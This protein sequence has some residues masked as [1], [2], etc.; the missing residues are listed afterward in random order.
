MRA[1]L[2]A[3][4]L[5]VFPGVTKPYTS[6]AGPGEINLEKAIIVAAGPLSKAEN[7]AV[8]ML[9][10][11]IEKRTLIRPAVRTRWPED[12]TPVIA[13]GAAAAAKAWAGPY[14]G[15]LSQNPVQCAA[16]GYTI[17]TTAADVKPPAVLVSG[18]DTRGV[19]YG[20]G[21]LLR[22]LNMSRGRLTLTAGMSISTAPRFPIRGHQ[23]GYRPKTNSYD[24]WTEEIWRQYI[25]DLAVFGTN[26][27]ELIPPRSDDAPDSPHFPLPQIDMMAKVSGILDDYDMDVWIWYPAME[28]DYSKPE[29]VEAELKAWGAV[30]A[31]LPRLN[32]VFVPGG[33][34]GHTAPAILMAFLEKM[35]SELHRYHPRAQM[36]MSPQS[37]NQEWLT[38]FLRIM[39]DQQ[40]RWLSGVV[41]GPQTRISL[42]ELRSALPRQYPIR[43]YP[44]ITHSLS[45]QYPVPDWDLAFALTEAREVINPRP[46]DEAMIF[47]AYKD[48]AQGFITYSEGCNDDVNKIIWSSLG[49]D[50][51]ADVNGVLRQYARYFIGPQYQDSFALGLLALERNWRGPLLGNESVEETLQL[52]QKMEREA[53]PSLLLNWRFQQALYRAYY[54]AYT[55]IRLRYESDLERQAMEK[56]RQVGSR[57]SLA[58]MEQA[59]AIVWEAEKTRTS[60]DLRTRV[61]QL[62]EALFQSIRMQLS[63]P[64]YRAISVDRGASLDTLDQPLNNRVWLR[65]RFTEIRKLP[66]EEQRLQAIDRILHWEDPGPDGFYDQLGSEEARPRLVPGIPYSQDPAFFRSPVTGFAARRGWRMSWCRHADALFDNALKMHYT[67]LDPQARYRVRVIYSGSLGNQVR[68]VADDQFEIHP[69]MAKPNPISPV[70]FDIPAAATR[71]GELTLSWTSTPGRGGAG[72]GPQVAEVWLIKQ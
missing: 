4:S 40:P 34:P 43:R 53:R 47:R 30:F 70:E 29:T 39:K 24:G 69:L 12:F 22:E 65:D 71:D 60:L 42:P 45:C 20:A 67:K 13:L 3:L 23:M 36:W 50:P 58:A 31:R 33:D 1:Q 49:W 15:L 63:V 37:F 9:A 52:F 21:R 16:E 2:I 11:E 72:R 59:E 56:L 44:D 7:T 27:V 55:Q 61:Y 54:D 18:N 17:Q 66:G 10:E 8:T 32:A 28:R 6:P 26:A 14:T 62:A 64:L 57:G 68:L 38:D 41:Y 51:D 46:I 35:T 5:L 25:R 48:Y 19:L